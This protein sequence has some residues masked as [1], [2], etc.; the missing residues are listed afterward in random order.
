MELLR[1]YA[2]K[3]LFIVANLKTCLSDDDL[4]SLFKDVLYRKLNLLCI[5]N[6]DRKTNKFENKIILDDDMCEI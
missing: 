6:C 4:E 3:Q 1:K 5:E 2:K